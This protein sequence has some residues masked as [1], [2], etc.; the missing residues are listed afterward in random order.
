MKPIVSAQQVLSVKDDKNT[1]IV[2]ARGGV[3]AFKRYSERHLENALHVDLETELSNK[4]PDAADGG[5][6]PLPDIHQFAITLGKLG[7]NTK[8]NVFVY[9]DKNAAMAAARFWWMLRAVGHKHIY[10]IDGGLN[11]AIKIGFPVTDKINYPSTIIAYP[12]TEWKMPMIKMNALES[13]LKNKTSLLIDVRE[14]Y[15]YK[16]ESEPI[17]LIAGHIPGA[18]NIPYLENLD[19]DGN[20]ISD[21]VLKNKYAILLKDFSPENIICQCG[22]GVTACHT[23]LALEQAGIIG[24]KLYV[25][26]WSEWSRNDKRIET[27]L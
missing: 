3:D 2:D 18:I 26:S 17:D 15:G 23:I 20:F 19:A 12:V 6:H 13:A 7:I 11:A 1:V 5:R 4:K 22:S 16:G 25:G 24:V 27:G 14:A 9:D 8:S 21:E 10:V